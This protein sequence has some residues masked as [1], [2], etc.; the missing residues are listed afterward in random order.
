[1]K[2]CL[3]NNLYKPYSR[4]GAEQVVEAIAN[5][6]QEV[7]YEIFIITTET[8]KQKNNL[9]SQ[10]GKTKKQNSASTAQDREKIYYLRGFYYNLNKLP[11]FLRLFWHILD[12]FDIGSY[13]QVKSI[14][15]QERPEV[16]I[17][18]NLKGISYLIPRAI[19]SLKIR[20]IHTLHDIQLLHPS[21][22]MIYGQERK[23][24]SWLAK[25]YAGFCLWLFSATNIVISP[26]KWLMQE[27]TKRGF[28]KDAKQIIL[29]N[30]NPSFPPSFFT[31]KKELGGKIFHF[32]YVGQIEEHKGI[33]FLIKVF[34]ELINE[35]NVNKFKLI[36]AG[37]GSKIEKARELA[38]DNKVI[39]F[40]GKQETEV[41]MEL[42][43]KAN[44]LIVPSLCYE[45]SPT[46]IYE[47]LSV[48]LPVIASRIGGVVELIHNFGGI[49]FT[50][51]NKS[52]LMKK[53]KWAVKNPL[54]L[55]KISHGY[56]EKFSTFKLENYI[57][58]LLELFN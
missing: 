40:I 1:M 20:H 16:V 23:I 39:K 56:Q 52:D 4:G 12:I 50:P 26:S 21:G 49:L 5:G 33:L 41:I 55:E 2:I 53:I 51:N 18:H 24:D 11:K 38:R 44:C 46:V 31:K 37:D 45:N 10:A 58:K 34:K 19:K 57:N 42:M 35:L 27:H 32:F 47:A 13:W 17:T 54:E 14:L 6:L 36:I 3:I 30:P 29:L 48:G 43:G 8:K 7:G 15:K 28:F 25:I 22:L 9:P